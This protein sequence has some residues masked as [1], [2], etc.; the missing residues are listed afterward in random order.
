MTPRPGKPALAIHAPPHWVLHPL[1]PATSQKPALAV[2]T[3]DGHAVFL[4]G[5]VRPDR[6]AVSVPS[7][8]PFPAAVDTRKEPAVEPCVG[9]HPLCSRIFCE[10]PLRDAYTVAFADF[11]PA[12]SGDLNG[13]WTL[14]HTANCLWTG[15]AGAYTLQLYHYSTGGQIVWQLAFVA[16]DDDVGVAVTGPRDSIDPREAPFVVLSAPGHDDPGHATVV[17]A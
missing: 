10:W 11:P 7:P 5:P 2:H 14:H 4:A 1:H 16:G 13:A 17:F 8:D 3:P 12:P 9:P 6:P 15:Q